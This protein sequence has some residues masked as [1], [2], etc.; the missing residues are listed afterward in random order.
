MVRVKVQRRHSSGYM[1]HYKTT[2][3]E[4]NGFLERQ[5]GKFTPM[6]TNEEIVAVFV[7]GTWR[8]IPPEK[9]LYRALAQTQND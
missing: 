7:E 6:S 1:S 3:D 5:D 4:T 8:S 2:A 9:N